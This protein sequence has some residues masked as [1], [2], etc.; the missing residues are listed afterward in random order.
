MSPP[1]QIWGVCRV[2]TDLA[3]E[4]CD[5]EPG[6]DLSELP[7]QHQQ[8]R[9]LDHENSFGQEVH[10]PGQVLGTGRGM[11]SIFLPTSPGSSALYPWE[12]VR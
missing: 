6:L 11:L 5:L 10:F 4:L 7:S 2:Q 9:I 1:S 3:E 12:T 8:S